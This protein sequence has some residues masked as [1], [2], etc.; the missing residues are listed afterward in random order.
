MNA[1]IK[2]NDDGS[3]VFT[4]D[5]KFTD[6]MIESIKPLMQRYIDNAKE[7]EMERD[8]LDNEREIELAKNQ[9]EFF[10]IQTEKQLEFS[11]LQREIQINSLLNPCGVPPLYGNNAFTKKE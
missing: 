8:R 6:A 10:K 7:V 3:V 2:R 9:T 4:F 5:D 11:R 1:T